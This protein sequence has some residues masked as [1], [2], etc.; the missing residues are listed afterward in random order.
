MTN[1]NCLQKRLKLLKSCST[2]ITGPAILQNAVNRDRPGP[3]FWPGLPKI[4]KE[5]KSTEILGYEN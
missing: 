1:L 4:C 3:G 5:V 2:S